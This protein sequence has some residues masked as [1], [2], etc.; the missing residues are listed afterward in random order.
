MNHCQNRGQL[1]LPSS[2][3][4]QKN[5]YGETVESRGKNRQAG[6][7]NLMDKNA[8]TLQSVTLCKYSMWTFQP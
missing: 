3:S 5:R 6:S 1:Q 4:I 7:A 2:Y 8:N